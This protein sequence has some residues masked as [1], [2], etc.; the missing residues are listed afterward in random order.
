MKGK[1]CEQETAGCMTPAFLEEER[2][3]KKTKS[4]MGVTCLTFLSAHKTD[5]VLR[6]NV[7]AELLILYYVV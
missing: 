5:S 4:K 1:C 6:H 2:E 7:L 3:K